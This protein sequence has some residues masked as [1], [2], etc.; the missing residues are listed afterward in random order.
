MKRLSIPCLF[1][2]F[3]LLSDPLS[4]EEHKKELPSQISQYLEFIKSKPDLFGPLGKWQNSEIEVIINPEQIQ[5]IQN[6]TRLRL[7]A[8]GF[9]E[10]DATRWS[11][12]GV[13]AED[14]YW[15]WIRDAVIFPSGVH[16]TYDRLLLRSGLNGVPGVVI[17]PLLSTKK[18]IVNV[19][20]RHATRSWEIELPRGHSKEG[21][22][23]EKTA[24]R[25]LKEETG[26]R[27]SKCSYLGTIAPDTGVLVSQFPVY[28]AEVQHSG[29]TNK[30]YSEAIIQNPA[31]S[32][33]ELKQGFSRGYIEIMIKGDI[34]KVN[35]RDPFLAYAIL[36]AEMKGLL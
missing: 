17:L 26:Y 2:S 12:V 13:V 1:L 19:N 10:E 15:I 7:I 35:C 30:E 31:F 22:T 24:M 18:I 8:Q 16:G 33:D 29:E 23:P 28:C 36:Q 3:L 5:K 14:N 25:E 11:S 32:K 20:Y 27:M 21:E 34:I 4:A 9:K 6:Q